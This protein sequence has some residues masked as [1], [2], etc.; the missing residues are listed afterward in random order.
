MRLA[1]ISDIHANLEALT[2]VL[3]DIDSQQID[4]IYC[5]GDIVGYGE[6]AH[7]TH[8]RCS[9]IFV[10]MQVKLADAAVDAIFQSCFEIWN[11]FRR[12][13]PVSGVEIAV[14]GAQ[15][16]YNTARIFTVKR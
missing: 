2:A 16:R 12:A 9:C 10:S 15:F 8:C 13:V 6:R 3:Q 14:I 11:D 5:L 4:Q 1:I 7:A